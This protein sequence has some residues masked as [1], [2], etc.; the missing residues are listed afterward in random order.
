MLKK[1]ILSLIFSCFVILFS[2]AQIVSDNDDNSPSS[3]KVIDKVVAQVGDAPIMLS[4]IK[5]QIVQMKKEGQAVN[6]S[7][8]CA[9]LE[10]SMY[11]KLLQIQ[12]K[13]DSLVV[14]DDQ[15]NAEMENRLRIIENKIGGREK[16]EKFY[17]KTYKQI[18]DQFREIIRSKMEAQQEEQSIVK[19]AETSPREVKKFFNTIPKDSIPYINEKM[20]IQQIVIYPKISQQSREAAIKKLKAWR[21]DIVSGKRSFKTMATLHSD[22]KGTAAKGGLIHASRGMMVKPFEAAAMALKPGEISQVVK[23]RYGYH[24]IKLIDRKGDDYTVRHILVTPEIGSKQLSQAAD[25]IDECHKRLEKHEIT[26]NQA[27]TEYSEDDATRQNQGIVTNPHSGNQYWDVANINQIDPQVYSL[28][29]GLKTG[30]ISDPA[31]YTDARSRKQGVRI[32]RIKDRIKPH[33]ANLKDDYNFIKNA[34]ASM[35]KEKII[36]KWVN[37]HA[38]NTYIRIDKNWKK[39]NFHYKW[40]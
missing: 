18:K 5:A 30:E 29:S 21:A 37:E 31:L 17:G 33:K 23:T 36:S 39:C 24:I 38:P 20:I 2:Q 12:A 1:S 8:K 14:T 27:V 3:R 9:I 16:L 7:M 10:R 19:D 13:K 32:V 34:A 22:D 35:K 40:N 11:Q 15:V 28:V 25:L 6:D 4:E 26:W